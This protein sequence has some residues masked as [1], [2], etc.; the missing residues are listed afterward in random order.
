MTTV[1]LALHAPELPA[2]SGHRFVANYLH[3]EVSRWRRRG[4]VTRKRFVERRY[5]WPIN[6]PN[7]DGG[8]AGTGNPRGPD[9]QLA[10]AVQQAKKATAHFAKADK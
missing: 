6:R 2:K 10:H 8:C 4:R 1:S 9:L 5:G 3:K 7:S